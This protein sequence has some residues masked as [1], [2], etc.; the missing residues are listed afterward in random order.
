[1]AQANWF[2]IPLVAFLPLILSYVWYHPNAM[3]S[4][5]AAI[6]GEQIQVERSIGKMLLIYLFS[7]LLAYILTLMSVHQSGIFQLFF[8][9]P[10]IANENSKYSLFI[11]EFMAEYGDRH[12]SFGHGMIHGAEAAL[13]WGLAFFG[14]TSLVQ[15]KP[16]KQVWIHL[17]FWVPC[18]SLMAGLLCAFF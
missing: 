6:T 3:G 2:I 16:F 14:V 17:G 8:M 13:F 1:M 18:C 7:V 11:K 15:N 10:E 9:D 12:R 4:R 5:L